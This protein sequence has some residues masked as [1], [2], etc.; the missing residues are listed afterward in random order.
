[1]KKSILYP[2]IISVVFLFSFNKNGY[3]TAMKDTIDVLYQAKIQ[4]ELMDVA[5]KFERIG[6]AEKDKWLPYYYSAY[7]FVLMST[8]EKDISKL[9][10]YLDIADGNIEKAEKL[11]GDIVEILTLKGF[12]SMMRI[13]V[14]PATR[15]QEYS[16]KSVAFL[17][18][19]NQ[20]DGQNPRVVLMLAQMQYGTAQFFGSGTAEA[21][22]QFSNAKKLFEEEENDSESILPSWGKQQAQVM[23]E[24]CNNITENR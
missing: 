19:A 15:G 11:K 20:L 24:Q 23:L 5:N 7:C 21:C 8:I 16:M 17:Q 6:I 22:A 4:Q 2:L 18:Q 1:M 14:D 12:S 9:D 13:G 10:G 3:H